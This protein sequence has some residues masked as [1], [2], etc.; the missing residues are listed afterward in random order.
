MRAVLAEQD[1]ATRRRVAR[2]LKGRGYEVDEAG[3]EK[4]LQA[5]IEKPLDVLILDLALSKDAGDLISRL[6]EQSSSVPVIVISDA[7]DIEAVAK[8]RAS[9]AFEYLV[10]PVNAEDLLLRLDLARAGAAHRHQVQK[11]KGLTVA[12]PQLHDPNSGRIDAEKV[13]EY[14][15]IPLKQ[16]TEALGRSY[17]AVHKTPASESVQE[18][19]KPIKRSLEILDQVIGAQTTIRAWLRSPHPDLGERA[20]LD[21]I[22]TGRSRALHALLENALSGIPS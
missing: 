6:H 12:L 8:A 16:L 4:L 5:A 22:L 21:V 15:G 20:P 14:M 3:N 7:Q 10:K 9:G 19:L 11:P 13:A 1:P 17:P 18:A 2:A